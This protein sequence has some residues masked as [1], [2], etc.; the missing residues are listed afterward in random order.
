MTKRA[1][2]KFPRKPRDSYDTPP[3]AVDPLFPHLQFEAECMF[4]EPCAGCGALIDT[5]EIR[6]GFGL[7][8]YTATDIHPRRDDVAPMDALNP[9]AD[10]DPGVKMIITNPPWDRRFLHPFIDRW[11]PTMVMWLLF[12]AD[13]AH[14]VKAA[15]Y[16]RACSD[17]VSIGRV[18]WEQNGVSG[19]D[20]CAWYRFDPAGFQAPVATRF[21]G[22]S[23]K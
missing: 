23:A 18:S 14:T 1:A 12:D 10:F 22:R 17:I 11:G 4:W 9:P 19:F 21:H 16:L 7:R 20:N 13:W 2:G 5:L 3:E 6:S 15:P 8:G